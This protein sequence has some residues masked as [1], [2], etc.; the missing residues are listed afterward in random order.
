[1]KKRKRQKSDPAGGCLPSSFAGTEQDVTIDNNRLNKTEYS[2]NG[3]LSV[4]REPFLSEAWYTVSCSLPQDESPLL[5]KVELY[6]HL[7]S[8]VTFYIYGLQSFKV[9]KRRQEFG[10]EM[11]QSPHNVLLLLCSFAF[12]FLLLLSAVKCG[13]YLKLHPFILTPFS[14]YSLSPPCIISPTYAGDSENYILTL[15]SFINSKQNSLLLR[16]LAGT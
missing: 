7:T 4:F 9:I 14:F 5:L 15:I 16:G 3:P 2:L 11:G 12:T 10:N 8:I 1:M 6:S 13:C